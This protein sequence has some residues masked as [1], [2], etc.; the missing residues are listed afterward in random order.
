[1]AC[2]SLG[3]YHQNRSTIISYASA[4]DHSEDTKTENFS[5]LTIR[6]FPRIPAKASNML[7]SAFRSIGDT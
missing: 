7:F 6:N 4:T 1:M 3:A 2:N 5:V